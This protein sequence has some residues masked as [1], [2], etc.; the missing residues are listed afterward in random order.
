MKSYNIIPFNHIVLLR[1]T[2]AT[3]VA[4]LSHR[5]SV[6]AFVCASVCHTGGS[7]KNSES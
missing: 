6:C 3:A 1:A 7:V 4:R 5:N 2:T